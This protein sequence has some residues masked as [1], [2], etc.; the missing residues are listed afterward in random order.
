MLARTRQGLPIFPRVG[1]IR[2]NIQPILTLIATM[3]SQNESLRYER[4]YVSSNTN[5]M[6]DRCSTAKLRRWV[7]SVLTI[8]ELQFSDR[9]IGPFS[10][11]VPHLS[12]AFTGQLRITF[13]DAWA[14]DEL[15]GLDFAGIVD[16]V[17]LLLMPEI[18]SESHVAL[19]RLHEGGLRQDTRS[20]QN[21]YHAIKSEFRKVP[22]LTDREKLN[23]FRTGLSDEL[24]AGAHSRRES[25]TLFETMY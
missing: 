19:T 4:S 1:P 9:Y 15:N 25:G 10:R 18:L 24:R 23:F 3:V 8:L 21:Y 17:E 6:S 11:I 22:D 7:V 2:S 16:W 5:C 14:S 12:S 20:L 13:D